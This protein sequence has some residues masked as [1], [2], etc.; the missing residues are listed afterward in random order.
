M[1]KFKEKKKEYQKLFEEKSDYGT[2]EEITPSK[3]RISPE[4]KANFF[5][6]ITYSWCSNL[7]KLGFQ[8]ALLNEDIFPLKREDKSSSLSTKFEEAWEVEKTKPNPSIL[9]T[10]TKEYGGL[11]LFSGILKLFADLLSFSGPILLQYTIRFISTPTWPT[12]YGLIIAALFFVLGILQIILNNYHFFLIFR[13]GV[14][15][16]SAIVTLI[17]KKGQQIFIQQLYFKTSS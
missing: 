16:R 7:L 13:V 12:Y 1:D 2:V 9:R 17:Y 11:Y 4:E 5:S 6:K 3:K 10:L 15:I 14:R 8:R